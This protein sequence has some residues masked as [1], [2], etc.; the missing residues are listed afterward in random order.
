MDRYRFPK[1][2][3]G[4]VDE[5]K[6]S[7]GIEKETKTIRTAI[8]ASLNLTPTQG[9]SRTEFSADSLCEL[10]IKTLCNFC[11]AHSPLSS[12]F[13]EELQSLCLRGLYFASFPVLKPHF[14]R[15]SKW[16]SLVML[17]KTKTR[18]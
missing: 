9:L 6:K 5:E 12:Q 8:S 18:L 7:E 13:L 10:K 11:S 1:N 2:R 16:I 3:K 17:G 14:E 15:I 4:E